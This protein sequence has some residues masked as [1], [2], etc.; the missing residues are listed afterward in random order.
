MTD[1]RVETADGSVCLAFAGCGPPLHVWLAAETDPA[2]L[3]RAIGIF[4]PRWPATQMA[5]DPV[6]DIAVTWTGEAYRIQATSRP[7]ISRTTLSI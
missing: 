6:P 7:D 4:M 2:E 3:Q 1:T 5:G